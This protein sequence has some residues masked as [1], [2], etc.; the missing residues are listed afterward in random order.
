[1]ALLTKLI[2]IVTPLILSI[3]VVVALRL[4]LY[5][6]Q[7]PDSIVQETFVRSISYSEMDTRLYR[8]WASVRGKKKK[9]M[10]QSNVSA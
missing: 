2:G 6:R 5:T 8:T 7:T 10:K 9:G 3:V 4:I 1:M